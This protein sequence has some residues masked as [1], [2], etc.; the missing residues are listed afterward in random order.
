MKKHKH[1]FFH[2]FIAKEIGLFFHVCC[3]INKNIIKRSIASKR[4]QREMAEKGDMAVPTCT[5]GI[6]DTLQNP[7]LNL[8]P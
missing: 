1:I 8:A 4:G 7:S 3:Q 6:P 5:A 2:I